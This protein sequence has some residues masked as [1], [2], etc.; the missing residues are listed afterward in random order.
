MATYYTEGYIQTITVGADCPACS[1]GHSLSLR[2]TE[3]FTFK[4]GNSEKILLKKEL[5]SQPG[6]GED[7][8]DELITCSKDCL[9]P[10]SVS[11]ERLSLQDI[12][13]LKVNKMK[14]GLTLEEC[15]SD[16]CIKDLKVL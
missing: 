13:L 12:L 11:P 16:F 1:R 4:E 6:A 7:Q 14:V 15:L 2:P 3:A 9:F 5:S 10:I 8:R